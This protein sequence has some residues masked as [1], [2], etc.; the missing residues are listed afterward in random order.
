M[1]SIRHPPAKLL[2]RVE[3]GI[4]RALERI[5]R[6]AQRQRQ[7]SHPKAADEKHVHITFGSLRPA[8]D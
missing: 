4:D 2:R 1:V 3:R 7:V 8:R 5:L 6:R